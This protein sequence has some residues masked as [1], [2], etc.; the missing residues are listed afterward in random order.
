MLRYLK[1]AIMSAL[2]ISCDGA[3]QLC[4][5]YACVYYE[6]NCQNDNNCSTERVCE[7]ASSIRDRAPRILNELRATQRACSSAANTQSNVALSWDDALTSASSLHSSD[8][9]QIGFT[10]FIGSDGST[11][12]IRMQNA[13]AMPEQF[14]ENIQSGTQTSAETINAWL[15]I[16]TDCEHMLNTA[17]TRMGMSCSAASSSTEGPYW[18]LI[19]AG[20]DQ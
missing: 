9:A 12:A 14:A 11:T 7:S 1:I 19:L 17:F 2:L 10:S 6:N 18:S 5:E 15:D 20:P 3:V 16:E 13:G 4:G 8:M